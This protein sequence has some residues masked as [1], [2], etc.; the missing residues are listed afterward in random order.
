MRSFFLGVVFVLLFSS[1]EQ[2]ANA[3]EVTLP[4]GTPL[5]CTLNEPNFSSAPRWATH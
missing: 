3:Q 5:N 4:A 2:S 1:F